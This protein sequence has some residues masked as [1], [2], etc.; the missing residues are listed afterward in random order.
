MFP[1]GFVRSKTA[2][3]PMA[4]GTT[5]STRRTHLPLTERTH[6]LTLRNPL[7]LGNPPS[8]SVA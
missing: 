3:P 2:T 5:S 8:L 1:D 4:E 6:F 7:V